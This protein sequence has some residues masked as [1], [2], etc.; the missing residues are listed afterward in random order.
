MPAATTAAAV[1]AIDAALL[2]DLGA[3]DPA[4]WAPILAAACARHGIAR[5]RQLAAF[6]ANVLHESGHL[7]HLVENLNYRADRLVAV[8][9][10]HRIDAATAAR[11]GR[12]ATRP[13]DQEAIANTVYGGT[14]GRT[15]LG[16]TEPGDGWRFRGRGLIQLTGRANYRKF[17]AT[18]GASLDDLPALL[19]K[20]AGAADSAAHFFVASGC[21]APADRDDIATVRRIINGGDKGLEEVRDLYREAKQVLGG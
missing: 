3:A 14:W 21:P 18:I 9:G 5:P 2:A 4:T 12:T 19:E 17:A 1:A 10:A 7:K 16:N 15:N 13:A 20:P 11:I 8:F 6:L